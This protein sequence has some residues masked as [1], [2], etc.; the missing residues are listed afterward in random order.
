MSTTWYDVEQS[1]RAWAKDD[2]LAGYYDADDADEWA[3]DTADGCEYT[4]YYHHQNAL[5]ADSDYVQSFEDQVFGVESTQ[6]RIQACVF[7]AINEACLESATE[8]AE[9][10]GVPTLGR[11]EKYI[12]VDTKNASYVFSIPVLTIRYTNPNR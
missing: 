12:Y 11:T 3:Q 2:W 6:E 10:Y 7:Y 4:I 5:W 9:E 1:V 8:V